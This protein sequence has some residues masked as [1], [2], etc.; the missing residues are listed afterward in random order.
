MKLPLY[1]A[2]AATA[3]LLSACA[4]PPQPPRP[5]PVKPPVQVNGLWYLD[6]GWSEEAR[7]WY[8]NTTQGSQIMRYDWF[9]ALEDPQTKQPFVKS[10]TRYGYAAGTPGSWNPDLLPVG[11]VKDTDPDKTTWFG[12]TC[13]ACH[14]GD[15]TVNGKTMRIDGAVT[16]GDLYGFIS[17]L[18]NA[19]HATVA[20]DAAFQPFAT[21][22]LGATATDQQKL[23]LYDQLT[24]FDKTFAAFVAASTPDTPWGS[25]R[26]DA[27]G[28]IFNRVSAIDL[29]LPKNNRAPNAPVSYPFLWDAPHQPRVQWNG[30]L[31]NATAFD[32]LGRNAGEVLG[33]FGKVTLKPPAD[34]AHYYYNSTVRGRNLVDMENQ[35]RKLRSP[36]WPD[37][38]AGNVDI[39]KAAA[40]E[41]IYKENCESCHAILPRGETYTTAPIQMVPLFN[42]AQP[43]N[44]KAVIAAFGTICTKGVDAAVAAKMVTVNYG[45]DPK[46]AVDALCRQVDTGAIAN[47]AMPPQLLGGKPLKNPDLAANLLSNAVIGAIFGDLVREPGLLLD[48]L[49]GDNAPAPWLT[50]SAP[51][52]WS[53]ESLTKGGTLDTTPFVKQGAKMTADHQKVI[54]ALTGRGQTKPTVGAVPAGGSATKAQAK[55]AVSAAPATGGATS[56]EEALAATIKQLLAYKARP[57]DGVWATAPFMHNGSVPNLYE[58]LL[59]VSQRSATFRMGSTAID[60]V[61][62]GVDSSAAGAT[63]VYDTTKPG[64]HNTGHEFGASL[65]DTQR[66]QLLEYLKTL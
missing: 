4:E 52:G 30:L 44:A 61:K 11:F 19:V 63:F 62:V 53:P 39:V 47:V 46:M 27:F 18:S 23:A 12:M 66:W 64:N 35:L 1:A 43:D 34:A 25:M 33:V 41:P 9:M 15:V 48:L 58:M 8:Y 56:D 21:R 60:P 22:V 3:L 24:A 36:V 20:S 38:L 2:L 59:P 37:S 55:A 29:N 31:P 32:A 49:K 26:T 50:A 16:T 28:M 65:T 6:Q 10:I 40:G 13:A 17:G 42:W 51:A 5:V 45:A 54:A 57:L 7:Q 14:T